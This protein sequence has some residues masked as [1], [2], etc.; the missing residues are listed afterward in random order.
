MT[1]LENIARFKTAATVAGAT[2]AELNTPSEIAA[3]ISK[4]S[5]GSILLSTSASITKLGLTQELATQGATVVATIS[6]ENAELAS[7][8]VTGVNFAIATTGTLVI[9][10][11]PEA[12]RL[13]STLPEKHFALLDPRKIVADDSEAVGLLRQFHQQ[14]PRNYLAWI[15]GPSR[16]ADIERVLTIGV[17]GPCELHIL[18][19]ENLSDDP[20]E[21]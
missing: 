3:Y 10:S 16:T 17:H 14:Q 8:G 13:A 1:A 7:G 4:H 18:L 6:R 15:T 11:T 2:I 5:A 21:G 19:V 9:E 20:L 12:I